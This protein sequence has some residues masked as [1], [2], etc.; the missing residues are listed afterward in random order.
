MNR[1]MHTLVT[2]YISRNDEKDILI[3][4]VCRVSFMPIL[5]KSVDF[6]A[7]QSDI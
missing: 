7:F 4:G 3:W 2:I 5:P 6:F 1:K